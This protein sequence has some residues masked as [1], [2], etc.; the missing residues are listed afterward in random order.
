MTETKQISKAARKALFAQGFPT[1]ARTT[2]GTLLQLKV[3]GEV[4]GNKG[5]W[6]RRRNPKRKAAIQWCEANLQ[7]RF[8]AQN[9][10]VFEREHDYILALLKGFFEQVKSTRVG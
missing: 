3:K 8:I 1:F 6:A 5:N 2:T 7:G 10:F 4:L 9:L